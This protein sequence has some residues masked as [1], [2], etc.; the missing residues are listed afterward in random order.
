M[1]STFKRNIQISFGLSLFI[2]IVSSAAS[3]FSINALLDSSRMVGRTNLVIQE[4]DN[5]TLIIKDAE[6]SQRGYLLTGLENFLE[7]YNGIRLR[8][9]TNIKHIKELTTDNPF[10]QKNVGQLNNLIEKRISYMERLIEFIKT[11]ISSIESF[12]S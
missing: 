11:S 1:K 12:P 8:A 9:L 3:F 7:P 2:L 5:V 10:Q 4:L 6:T